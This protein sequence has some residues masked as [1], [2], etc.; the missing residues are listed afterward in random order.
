MAGEKG[1]DVLKSW[2]EIAAYIDRDIRTCQRWEKELRLPIL[3]ISAR[4]KA[5]IFA[6]KTELDQ[7]FVEK[8]RNGLLH[9]NS[10]GALT[11]ED[12]PLRD[13]MRRGIKFSLSRRLFVILTLIAV[14]AGIII[15]SNKNDA[16]P[17]DF[18][19][20]GSKLIIL[21]DKKRQIGEFDTG[22]SD[23]LEE[24]WYR[25]HFQNKKSPP[26]GNSPDFPWLVFRDINWDGIIEI[27][28]VP[29]SEQ[30]V[31]GGRLYC[32]DTNGE[33]RWLYNAG[34][35]IGYGDRI[36]PKDFYIRGFDLF[37]LNQDGRTEILVISYAVGEYP[38]QIAILDSDGKLLS[39][40]WNAGQISNYSVEDIDQDGRSE[41][42]LGGQNNEYQ[43]GAFCILDPAAIRGGS[44]Q[45]DPK[46]ISKDMGPGTEQYYVLLPASEL[47]EFFNPGIS[48]GF[49]YILEGNRIS[50]QL[51]PS[52]LLFYFTKRMELIE[53]R[54]GH[55]FERQ[56][57]D[58]LR[59]GKIQVP[60]NEKR[61]QEELR[62]G[63]RYWDG[64][65]WVNTPTMN[66]FWLN[67]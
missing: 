66:K 52:C 34:K 25:R 51:I 62:R 26:E 48:V 29:N 1:N 42:L 2:K 4:R 61:I 7:W 16:I 41:I 33:P 45:S 35:E 39:E 32:L 11:T 43:K 58:N 18:K 36:F 3:R 55:Y 54:L 15:I 28:F 37:D 31:G 57:K 56:Y 49:F 13:T 40:Y 20:D 63:I 6:Y 10:D 65:K 19:I 12:S 5:S 38:T 23:L 44:P 53:P 9:R 59:Q 50:I 22:L 64:D 21:N 67:R 46:Y 27:F 60:Y 47:D 24:S 17:R 8:S 30:I 14:G